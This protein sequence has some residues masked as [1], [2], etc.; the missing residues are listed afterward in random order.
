MSASRSGWP[1]SGTRLDEEIELFVGGQAR[2][3]IIEKI[4]KAA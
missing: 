2:K 1:C 3:V 4:T